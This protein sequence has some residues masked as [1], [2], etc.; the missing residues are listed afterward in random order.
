GADGVAELLAGFFQ[1][2]CELANTGLPVL[3]RCILRCMLRCMRGCMVCCMLRRRLGLV[4]CLLSALGRI[5]VAVVLLLRR[6]QLV[7]Q[8]LW[9]LVDEDRQLSDLD[10]QNGLRVDAVIGL[11]RAVRSGGTLAELLEALAE[12]TAAL[13]LDVGGGPLQ[14]LLSQL[15]EA[16]RELT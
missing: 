9:Q 1:A 16:L 15:L 4:A 3:V 10:R 5:A 14:R 8:V 12:L 13:I 7:L 2:T 6:L 11:R